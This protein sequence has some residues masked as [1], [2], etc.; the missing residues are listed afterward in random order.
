MTGQGPLYTLAHGE[1][2]ERDISE[3][4]ALKQQIQD[5]GGLYCD[6]YKEKC[7]RRRIAVRMRARGV[8]AFSA[9][10]A[11]LETDTQEYARLLEA[12]AINVS[13]FFRNAD[14]WE[15]IR[16]HIVPRLFE[17]D[18]REVRIWSAGCAAGEEPYTVAMLLLEHAAATGDDVSRF[19]ILGT[20]IDT[21]A[22]DAARRAEYADFAFGEIEPARRERW[23]EGLRRDRVRDEVRALVDFAPLDLITDPFPQAQHLVLCRNVI[24]YFER[25]VQDAI[26]RRFHQAVAPDSWLVLGKVEALFG[27]TASLFRP[28]ANRERLFLRS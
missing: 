18:A 6:G 19:R 7:L 4:R 14:V 13:K 11:L 8:H 21:G 26:F 28:V 12:V 23:F 10:A 22:L 1:L 5:H 17:I 16:A 27:P 20:D 25:A 2:T 3:L 15:K 9:Y 24:I